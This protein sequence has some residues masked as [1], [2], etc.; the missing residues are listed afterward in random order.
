MTHVF[1]VPDKSGRTIH[2]SKERWVH[3]NREHPEVTPYFEEIKEC[4]RSPTKIVS[5]SFDEKVCQYHK[6]LKNRDS[7][8]KY[9]L[10]IVKY[11]NN[12]GFVITA[13]FVRHAV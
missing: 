1:N 5:Y 6:Y 4:L 11:L 9:L 12:H 10:L 3:I 2:L 8:A 13:Y 7:D